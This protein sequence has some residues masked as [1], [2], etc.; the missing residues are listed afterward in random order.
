M[1][2]L[3]LLVLLFSAPAYAV[4]T[5]SCPCK[6]SDEEVSVTAGSFEEA[7][8]KAALACTIETDGKSKKAVHCEVDE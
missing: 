1:K 4:K 8:K 3:A 2:Y 6:N 7:M 5:Y